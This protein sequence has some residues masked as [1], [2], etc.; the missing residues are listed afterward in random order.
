[1]KMPFGLVGD[2]EI[3]HGEAN[4]LQVRETKKLLIFS[5]AEVLCW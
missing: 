2:K 4:G 5:G 1:M 3:S